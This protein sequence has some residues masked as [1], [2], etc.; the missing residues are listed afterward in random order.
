MYNS[1]G[2]ILVAERVRCRTT[3][4]DGERKGRVRIVRADIMTCRVC[5]VREV[6]RG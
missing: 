6:R 5:E 2:A 1:M 3:I 4:V